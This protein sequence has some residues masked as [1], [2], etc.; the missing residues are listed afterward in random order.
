[1]V[2]VLVVSRVGRS[3]QHAAVRAAGGTILDMKPFAPD[4]LCSW[5]ADMLKDAPLEDRAAR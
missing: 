1:M 5:V 2:T 4:L 3:D